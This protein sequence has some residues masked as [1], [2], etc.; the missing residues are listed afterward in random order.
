MDTD[1][2]V[3]ALKKA[4]ATHGTPETFN[5]DQC[6]QFTSSDWIEVLTDAKIKIWT[7]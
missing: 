3:E 2:C 6:S 1:F 7:F 4:L 5:T